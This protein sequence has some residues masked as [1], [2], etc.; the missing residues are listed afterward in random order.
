MLSQKAK[1][2]L[3]ALLMLA[4]RPVGEPLLI[5][6]IAAR[7]NLPRKFLELILLDLKHHEAI[8]V[9]VAACQLD[10]PHHRLPA[11]GAGV[12]GTEWRFRH[13]STR[14][15]SSSRSLTRRTSSSAVTS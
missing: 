5:A 14:I 4:E 10:D 11:V 8:C 2:A 1:Y 12:A 15:V 3:R 9:P 13:R 6:E 7:Q